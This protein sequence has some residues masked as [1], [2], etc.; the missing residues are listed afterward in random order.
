MFQSLNVIFISHTK[1]KEV[2]KEW[3]NLDYCNDINIAYS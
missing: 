1:E 3:P 2:I